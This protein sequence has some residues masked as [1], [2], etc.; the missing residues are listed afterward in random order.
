M[1]IQRT[2]L[3]NLQK[4]VPPVD[5]D[6]LK[7][8]TLGRDVWLDYMAVHY[9]FNYIADG[10]S[11]VKVLVGSSGC[12]KS[13]LL[14]SVETDARNLGYETVFL[15]AR[16]TLARLN[17]LPSLY[18]DIAGR[19]DLSG[20]VMGLC[21]LVANHL[22]VDKARYSNDRL[23]LEIL[24]ED[25][26]PNGDAIREIREATGAVFLHADLGPSFR[27][28]VWGVVK[29]QLCDEEGEGNRKKDLYLK[30]IVGQKLTREEQQATNLFER[31]DRSNSRYWLNSLISL[32]RL[33]NQKGLLVIVDDL[34]V[35]TERS[36]QTG[37]YLYRPTAVGDTCELFRQIIDDCEILNNF[38]LLLAGRP[39]Y[40]EDMTRGII[41]Y[42]ALWMRLQSGLVLRSHFN[43]FSDM[44]NVDAHYQEAGGERFV[45]E[46]EQRL[47]TVLGEAGLQRTNQPDLPYDPE[48]GNLRR[49]VRAVATLYKEDPS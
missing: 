2:D 42:P 16:T 44:V 47:K 31:V 28:F 19:I 15:S 34:E 7:A 29:S 49:N 6:L 36:L 23:L 45:R 27:T 32:L 38:L 8:I 12:G 35:M 41:S 18:Q 37:R 3:E 24:M 17:N 30:W 46:L 20:M 13:H 33:A 9:L 14:R 11:K 1:Q 43:P 22:G 26:M 4:G 39:P 10:G 25:G 48:E 40:I 5:P 21:L